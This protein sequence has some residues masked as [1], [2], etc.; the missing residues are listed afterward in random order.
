VTDDMAALLL[1]ALRDVQAELHMIRD[2]LDRL[3]PPP[4][5][6]D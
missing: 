5:R 2:A 3:A 6:R 1:A 4:P